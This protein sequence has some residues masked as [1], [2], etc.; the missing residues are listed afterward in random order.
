M[1]TLSSVVRGLRQGPH[2]FEVRGEGVQAGPQT[3]NVT[4]QTSRVE[5]SGSAP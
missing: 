4:P 2:R 3:V 1:C 5:L